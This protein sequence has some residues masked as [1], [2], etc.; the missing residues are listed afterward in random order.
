[1]T[2]QQQ[3]QFKVKYKVSVMVDHSKTDGVP[4][5][6]ADNPT[7]YNLLRK[8][9]YVNQM[10]VMST[11]FTRIKP[12]FLHQANGGYLIIQVRDILTNAYVWE[13]LKRAIKYQQIHIE[14]IGKQASFV[15]MFLIKLDSITL[16]VKVI[17]IVNRDIYLLLYQHDEDFRKLIKVKA[18]FDVEMDADEENIQG[19]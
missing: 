13:G 11:D 2:Q 9:E 17:L 8:V 14:N 7:Y 12:G 6:E 10:G 5:I 16:N 19:L 4:V 15:A 3:K 1:M 18:E